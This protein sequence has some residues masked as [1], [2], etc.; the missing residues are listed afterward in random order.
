MI[1]LSKKVTN[2]SSEINYINQPEFHAKVQN[3][4]FWMENK[5][6]TELGFRQNISIEEIVR[7]L[8]L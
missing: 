5:K 3:K 6:I 1:E 7:E 8:C 2:S 4:D